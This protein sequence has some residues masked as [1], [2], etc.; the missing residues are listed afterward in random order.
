[1]SPELRNCLTLEN[2]EYQAGLDQLLTLKHRVGIVLDVHHHL[3]KEEVYITSTDA[4]I[5]QIKDSWCGQRPVIHYSQ[6]RDDIIGQFSNQLPK[7]ADM[8]TVAKKAKLRAHS[9]YYSNQ[10]INDWA[11][12]HL[13][14]AD[15]MAECKFKNLAAHQLWLYHMSI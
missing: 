12:T 2:D 14:W 7:M 5:E 11:L 10:Y 9:D 1:M 13:S 4:R 15:I 3:I 8:L 6:S